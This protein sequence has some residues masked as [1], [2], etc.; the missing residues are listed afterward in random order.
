MSDFAIL[1]EL[2]KASVQSLQLRQLIT[3]GRQT[4]S[5]YCPNYDHALDQKTIVS[6]IEG[7]KLLDIIQHPN[8]EKYPNQRIFIVEI[9]RYVYLV[10]FIENETE[11][12]LKTII[13]SRK[14]TKKYLGE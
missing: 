14:M 3:V 12:F 4:G 2:I 11:F 13:P 9:D 1:N 10:P 8:Q 5:R 6:S 7:D